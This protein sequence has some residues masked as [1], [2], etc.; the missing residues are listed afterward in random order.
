M[1][2]AHSLLLVEDSDEDY[3]IACWA[4]RKAGFEGAL[5]RCD[6]ALAAL[7]RLAPG[8]APL[9]WAVLVDL[10]LPG[11]DGKEL[12]GELRCKEQAVALPLVV[13]ST[14]TNP[15]D[16]AA[17]YRLGAAGYLCKPLSIE[18]YVEKL[19]G[20]IDYLRNIV[21]LPEQHA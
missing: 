11:M 8:R 7:H 16:I 13:L 14:S 1:S 12:L 17:C 3:E 15:Q 18:V 21:A 19:R 10:N 9:P 6:N 5:E 4:L 2:D 20:L